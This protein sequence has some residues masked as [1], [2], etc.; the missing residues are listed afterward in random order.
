MRIPLVPGGQ[1]ALQA[2]HSAAFQCILLT[3]HQQETKMAVGRENDEYICW[4]RPCKKCAS[5][6]S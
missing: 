5:W 6:E 1:N 4:N 2:V 3:R